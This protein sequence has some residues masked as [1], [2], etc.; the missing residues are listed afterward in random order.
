MKAQPE[1][2]II[3]CVARLE[4]YGSTTVVETCGAG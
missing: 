2:Q 1:W 3:A 4:L